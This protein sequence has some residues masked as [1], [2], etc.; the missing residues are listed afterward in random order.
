M[1]L[2]YLRTSGS[3]WKDT[4]SPAQSAGSTI[5][6]R[7]P[8]ETSAVSDITIR[9]CQARHENASSKRS[10]ANTRR[11]SE[12]EGNVFARMCFI[13]LMCLS[14]LGCGSSNES[15][16]HKPIDYK[17][18]VSQLKTYDRLGSATFVTNFV[19][20]D[21]TGAQRQLHDYFG[22]P[23]VVTFWRTTVPSSVTELRDAAMLQQKYKDRGVIFLGIPLEE[24]APRQEM[25]DHVTS[26][27]AANAISM[28]QIVGSNELASAFGG[29]DILPTVLI[30]SPNDKIVA[31]FQ[32]TQSAATIETQ[33]QA[34]LLKH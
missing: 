10:N 9:N 8:F 18:N 30:I 23:L 21:S 24:K 27:I 34:I 7:A 25:F 19:W 16:E 5:N 17:A 12:V 6:S 33:L 26:A 32:G 15:A 28:Q 2:P 29:I 22:S 3:H 1:R 11:L 31:T 14:G 4:S 13:A 20:W